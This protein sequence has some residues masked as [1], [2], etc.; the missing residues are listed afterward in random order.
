M[1]MTPGLSTDAGR[2]PVIWV[3]DDAALFSAL[4]QSLLHDRLGARVQGFTRASAFLSALR[5]DRPDLAI[6]DIR[7]PPTFSME[8]LEAALTV[9]RRYP[10]VAIL[11]LSNHLEVH[12]L[13]QLVS[14]SRAGFG[15]LLKERV[16]GVDEFLG[17]MRRIL[18]GESVVDQEVVDALLGQQ[19][20][21][22]LLTRLSRREREVLALMA[23]GRSNQ[24]ICQVLHVSAKTL[25]THVTSI[26]NRLELVSE[27]ASARAGAAGTNRRV[28]AVLTYVKGQ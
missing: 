15:Y 25:E 2:S 1:T 23:E 16:A 11:V 28:L 22:D 10:H 6:L 17:A 9:M 24:A 20:H 7:L 18:A 13:R 5:R 21:R 27:A 4:L 19:R 14:G 8:G 26:F 3:V 12:H